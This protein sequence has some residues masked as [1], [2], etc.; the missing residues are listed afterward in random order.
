MI[1]KNQ[2]FKQCEVE[3]APSIK[4]IV[5]MSTEDI[6]ASK[7]VR[8]VYNSIILYP[9]NDCGRKCMEDVTRCHCEIK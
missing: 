3:I 6:R 8:K 9:C 5:W 7:Q 2:P 4:T 1:S